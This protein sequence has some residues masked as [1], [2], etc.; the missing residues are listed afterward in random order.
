MEGLTCVSVDGEL[1]LLALC[2][3]N[4]CL[5]GA[6]GREPGGG[7]IQVFRRAR[8]GWDHVATIRLPN[9]LPFQDFSSV[10]VS[11]ERIAVLSQESAALWL[12][13]LRTPAWEVADDG[14]LY[15]FPLD[16]DGRTA[17]GNAEGVAWLSA[18]QVVIVSDRVKPDQPRR[19]RAKD[20]SIDLI[21][22]HDPRR[23]RHRR[24]RRRRHRDRRP[25]GTA[26]VLGPFL[27]TSGKSELNIFHRLRNGGFPLLSENPQLPSG[28]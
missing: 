1:H 8:G 25:V 18:D 23:R 15:R 16:D 2:E 21:G 28:N 26:E 22:V 4:R 7:R 9:T 17:Y 13:T 6:A 19:Y 14:V 5:G 20:E 3:G 12:G 24:R 10:A 27:I 11:G